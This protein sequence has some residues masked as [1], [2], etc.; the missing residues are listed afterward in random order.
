MPKKFF[1]YADRRYAHK[2]KTRRLDEIRPKTA[3]EYACNG[4]RSADRAAENDTVLLERYPE[5]QSRRKQNESVYY[6][7]IQN[8][9]FQ[10]NVHSPNYSGIKRRQNVSFVVE[11]QYFVK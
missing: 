3:Y 7:I 4:A 5:S 2:N 9:V 6:E 8:Y 10:V 1:S 11:L